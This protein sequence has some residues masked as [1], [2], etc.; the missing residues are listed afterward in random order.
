MMKGVNYGYWK[1]P[2]SWSCVISRICL[3]WGAPLRA[4]LLPK[5]WSIPPCLSSPLWTRHQFSCKAQHPTPSHLLRKLPVQPQPQCLP[6]FSLELKHHFLVV[7][8]CEIYNFLDCIIS[9]RSASHRTNNF[10]IQICPCHLQCTWKS[11]P[12]FSPS[13]KIC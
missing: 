10:P 7:T 12:D 5:G 8:L 4:C 6:C 13:F 2:V 9:W 3:W 1:K 11:M